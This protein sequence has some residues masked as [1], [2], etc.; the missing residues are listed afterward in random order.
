[1]KP[2]LKVAVVV[3]GYVA[4]FC[5]AVALVAI[6]VAFTSGPAAQASSGMYAFG[7]AV[8]FVG[9]FGTAALVPTA[10]ALWFLRPYRRFWVALAA[11]ALTL[12]LTAVAAAVVFAVG[13]QAPPSSPLA[14]WAGLSV[15][16]IL[17]TPVLAL[18][19]AL[20]AMLSPQ[21]LS[22]WA[23]LAA[24]AMEGAASVYGALVW[25]GPVLFHWR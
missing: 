13:R 25:F 23:L 19:F 12:A 18:F 20:C 7:D 15:L 3:G 4:A 24:A 9:V 2:S 5:L 6:H 22:R 14:T 21:P 11:L 10:V 1:M 17:L 16:R 8:L